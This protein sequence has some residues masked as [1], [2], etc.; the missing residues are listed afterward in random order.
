[1]NAQVRKRVGTGL[2]IVGVSATALYAASRIL[3]TLMSKA[4]SSMMRR[5]MDRE[6][7]FN[8]PEM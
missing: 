6:G 8:P 7:G 1:M 4:M 5:M 2:L 3:P